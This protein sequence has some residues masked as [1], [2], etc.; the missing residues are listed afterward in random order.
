MPNSV[1]LTS[2]IKFIKGDTSLL[3]QVNI[4]INSVLKKLIF[5][6]TGFT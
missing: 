5:T 6:D 1:F 4:F 3:L 2:F